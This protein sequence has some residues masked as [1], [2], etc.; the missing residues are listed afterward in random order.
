MGRQGNSALS[1]EDL[2]LCARRQGGDE[3][4]RCVSDLSRA[5][6]G[7]RVPPT[8]A[9]CRHSATARRHVPLAATADRLSSMAGRAIPMAAM[10]GRS[11]AMGRRRAPLAWMADRLC[12]M[13]RQLVAMV[14]V[15]VQRMHVSEMHVASDRMMAAR[16][17]E[18][19]A[20][21]PHPREASRPQ[22]PPLDA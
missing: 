1:F 20:V 3:S 21:H 13:V 16:A 15:P 7:Y 12:H 8:V 22:A 18:T 6:A 14:G 2:A 9:P 4:G 10:A 19:H 17:P 11:A 5:E